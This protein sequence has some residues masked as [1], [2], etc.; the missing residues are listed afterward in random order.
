MK[1]TGIS[2]MLSLLLLFIGFSFGLLLSRG[3]NRNTI[4]LSA[5]DST[6][7]NTTEESAH[8]Q[9]IGKININTA[10]SEELTDLP[11]IGAVLAARII[12]YRNLSGPF[13]SIDEL[14][15]VRGI[16]EQRLESISG[17]ITV[18]G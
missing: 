6:V 3:T 15:N 10:T 14:L 1:K 9:N 18:G 8:E 12:E 17:Y 11:G 16:G 4:P 7:Q 13:K 2:I 5:Y